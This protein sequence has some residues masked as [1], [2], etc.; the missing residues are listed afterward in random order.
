MITKSLAVVIPAYKASFLKATLD[1]IAA[2]T[3]QDFTLY[4]GDD[5]SPHN[6]KNI[7]DGYKDKIDLVY[8]RFDTNLGGRDLVAQWERCIAMTKEEPYIWLFSD[9][10]VMEP[11]CVEAF[12]NLPEQIRNGYIVHFPIKQIDEKGDVIKTP[13]S[14]PERMSAKGY[15]DAKLFQKGIISYVVEFVFPRHIYKKTS[16][17]QNYDLAWGSDFMT[18]LKF[19]E[20]CNGIYTINLEEAYVRWRS[21]SE[22]IS[23]NK[24]RDIQIRKIKSQIEVAE[25]VKQFLIRNCYDYKFRYARFV[26]GDIKRSVP[27]FRFSD[28]VSLCNLFRRKI[29]YHLQTALALFVIILLKTKNVLIH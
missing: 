13:I 16:G 11:K 26:L 28:I 8:K 3:C 21:S 5:C 1:S 24:S 15:L 6:L 23:P 7:V 20:A 9:D 2:Q 12:L 22:N 27:S 25:Y 14:Y 17:F 29:G 4:I 18:W 19:A 10:D